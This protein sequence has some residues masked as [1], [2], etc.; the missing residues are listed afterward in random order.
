M[1][2]EAKRASEQEPKHTCTANA[3]F[4]TPPSPKSAILQQ[5]NAG[6]SLLGVGDAAAAFF[7]EVGFFGFESGL[8]V[9]FGIA[10][11]FRIFSGSTFCCC[12]TGVANSVTV[13][14]FAGNS[15]TRGVLGN[16]TGMHASEGG[17]IISCG[18]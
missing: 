11:S 9:D 8:G 3:V 16:E 12:L 14:L 4:P 2:C 18:D 7:P 13:G 6:L 5:S 17:V 1:K 15:V 10:T